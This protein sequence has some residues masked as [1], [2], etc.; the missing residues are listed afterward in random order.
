MIKKYVPDVKESSQTFSYAV[1]KRYFDEADL[2]NYTK[3]INGLID[4]A[5]DLNVVILKF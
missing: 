1:T 3:M 5:I 2:G 4:V